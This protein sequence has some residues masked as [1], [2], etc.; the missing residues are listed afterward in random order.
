M[1][2]L[3][4]LQIDSIS[5]RSAPKSLMAILACVPERIWSIRCPNGWPTIQ[6]TPG[7]LR[8]RLR[9]SSMIS[10]FERLPFMKLTSISDELVDC[11]CSS[12]SPRPVR[13]VVLVTSGTICNCRSMILPR[14]SLSLSET[15][16]LHTAVIVNEPSLKSGKKLEPNVKKVTRARIK[17]IPVPLRT[18]RLCSNTQAK[19]LEYQFWMTVVKRLSLS[20][21]AR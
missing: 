14:W 1:T 16:G 19:A 7:T 13:R 8:N 18:R 15:P 3:I 5:F 10:A 4:R 17:S 9:T 2:D 20:C 6:T 11:E 21:L 12:S